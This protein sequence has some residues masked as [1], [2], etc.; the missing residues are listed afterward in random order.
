[1]PLVTSHSRDSAEG[2]SQ[3]ISR[4]KST[5]EGKLETEL[6]AGRFTYQSWNFCGCLTRKKTFM[7][8]PCGMYPEARKELAEGFKI[9]LLSD[10]AIA[11]S[12]LDFF[13]VLKGTIA[14]D[15]ED[16][17]VRKMARF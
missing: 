16:E 11:S 1:M 8:L 14:R 10:E 12:V 17:Q 5:T 6:P 9:N 4:P 2:R 7:Y 13:S 3:Q 15:G